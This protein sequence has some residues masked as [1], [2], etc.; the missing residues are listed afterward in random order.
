MIFIDNCKQGTEEWHQLRLG[1]ITSSRIAEV[2]AL[3]RN[4]DDVSKTRESYMLDL[5]IQRITGVIPQ[6]PK[7]DAINHGH[8]TENQAR[9]MY[10]LRTGYDVREVAFVTMGDHIGV[11]P[12][13]LV[14]T[15]G[16]LEIKCPNTK[17]QCSRYYNGIVLPEEYQWQVDSQLWVTNRE[18]C[19]FVQF[20]SR[21][22]TQAGYMC[23]RIY[24]SEKII[25]CMEQE[26]NKFI[27]QLENMVYMLSK[28]LEY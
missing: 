1:R 11:S 27:D 17:T 22:E 2:M 10:E 5:A 3:A 13:G 25:K 7:S 24:R 21:I 4:P 16:L 15:D 9:A 26:V 20:D 19:D 18:W 6:G 14:D 23:N 12:D 8:E 28:P